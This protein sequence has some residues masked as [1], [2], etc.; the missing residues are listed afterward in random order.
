MINKSIKHVD[1]WEAGTTRRL[2]LL[3]EKASSHIGQPCG[4]WADRVSVPDLFR[5]NINAQCR[6]VRVNRWVRAGGSSC[7]ILQLFKSH[8]SSEFENQTEDQSHYACSRSR[9]TGR[10]R[11][12]YANR[13]SPA[14]CYSPT[15]SWRSCRIPEEATADHTITGRTGFT[16]H[17]SWWCGY[18]RH[19]VMF[20]QMHWSVWKACEVN[21]INPS[22]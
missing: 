16:I 7:D 10:K 6:N 9:P 3:F 20:A 18:M 22:G 8:T 11:T 14:M 17:V 4:R 21:I 19:H 1:V 13:G 2:V 15:R 5:R 12:C